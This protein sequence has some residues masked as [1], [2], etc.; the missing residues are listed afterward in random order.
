V[1]TL[2]RL[3]SP[4]IAAPVAHDLTA[5]PP[6]AVFPYIE[7]RQLRERLHERGTFPPLEALKIVGDVLRGLSAA[8]RLGVVHCDVKPDTLLLGADG[9]AR[10]R[11]PA[12]SPAPRPPV[13]TP[14]PAPPR[15]PPA[16]PAAWWS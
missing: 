16:A 12:A 5:D 8:H 6:Y 3:Q 9:V 14:P 15:P 4:H 7:G 11:R 13:L 1:A 2:S 10:V